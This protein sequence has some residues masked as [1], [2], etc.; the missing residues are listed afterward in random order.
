M[1]EHLRDYCNAP[2]A[3]PRPP[4][5]QAQKLQQKLLT[6]PMHCHPLLQ[7][8]PPIARRH[9][10][11]RRH[12]DP[13]TSPPTLTKWEPNHPRIPQSNPL[14][15]SQ[16]SMPFLTLTLSLRLNSPNRAQNRKTNAFQLL[17]SW[18]NPTNQH[19][20]TYY[21]CQ[22]LQSAYSSEHHYTHCVCTLSN[23]T[24]LT[25]SAHLQAPPRSL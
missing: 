4:H 9:P 6:S 1:Q 19:L 24:T 23:I 2:I 3:S 8:P 18:R 7:P 21:N 16:N 25:I 11:Q 14:H 20:H 13:L 10:R 12:L 17:T 22:Y 5:L 15:P